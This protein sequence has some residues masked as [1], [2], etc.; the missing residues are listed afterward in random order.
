MV[1]R[2]AF[3]NH[4]TDLMNPRSTAEL[5]RMTE[6]SWLY[7]VYVAIATIVLIPAGSS[8][9]LTNS[10]IVKRFISVTSYVRVNTVNQCC[11]SGS[12]ISDLMPF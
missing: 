7:P 3:A 4:I 11:R 1:N 6:S 12:R 10:N 2:Q 9:N 5:L 8:E